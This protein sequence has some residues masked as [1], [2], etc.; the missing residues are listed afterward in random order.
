[1]N[2]LE[3]A[4]QVVVAAQPGQIAGNVPVRVAAWPGT[5]LATLPPDQGV[6]AECEYVSRVL[7]QSREA[8]LLLRRDA[9]RMLQRRVFGRLRRLAAA[10]FE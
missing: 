9:E 6:S 1:M 3:A 5:L 4:L 10:H 8:E 2:E 7:V